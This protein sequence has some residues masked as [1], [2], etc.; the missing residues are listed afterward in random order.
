MRIVI[1]SAAPGRKAPPDYV[2]SLA[3]GMKLMGHYVDVLDAWTGDGHRLPG[4]DY[5][6]VV[7]QAVSSFSGKIPEAVSTIL[8]AA[9]SVAG[10]KGAAFVRKGGLFTARALANLMKAMEKEGMRVN[11]SDILLNPPHA[12]AMGKL[13]GA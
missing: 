3:K 2:L 6:V 1:I 11:W 9:S 7:T 4:Y 12:E 13:I 5:I 8:S 10:K